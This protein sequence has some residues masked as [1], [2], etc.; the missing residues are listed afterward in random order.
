[1]ANSAAASEI[2]EARKQTSIMSPTTEDG[3]GTNGAGAFNFVP[4]VRSP[5][6]WLKQSKGKI[7]VV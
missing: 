3:I 4:Q 6:E 5:K 7:E 1:M 2:S